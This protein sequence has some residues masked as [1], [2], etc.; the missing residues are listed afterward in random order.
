MEIIAFNLGTPGAFISLAKF[1]LI[2]APIP[3][4]IKSNPTM[5]SIFA[6]SMVSTLV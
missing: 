5:N 2:Y 3:I 4:D 6:I 1:G